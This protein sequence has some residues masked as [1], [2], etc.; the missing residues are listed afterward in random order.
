MLDHLNAVVSAPKR[1]VLIGAGGFVGGAIKSLLDT[2][3]VPTLG[4]TRR[5]IDLLG[6]GAT[7]KVAALL[8]PGDSVV[9]VSAIA[10]VKTVS[11][12]MQN[13]CMGQAVCDAIARAPIH[14]LLYISSDAVYADDA[15]P[16]TERS[17]CA[18]STLHGMMH[19]ARELMFKSSTTAPVAMLRPT[20]I[21]GAADPHGGYGPNRFRR[22]AA[23]GED[24][25]L[26]GE[27]EEQRDHVCIDDVAELARLIL[28]HRS[29]GALNA[30]TGIATSFNR[31]AHVIAHQFGDRVRVRETP[32]TV[33]RPHL[34][35][36][37]FDITACH[38]A[39]PQFRFVA[40]EEGLARAMRISQGE[41]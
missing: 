18:P 29:R 14:H 22:Q 5:E 11:M 24:I 4:I 9:I 13:L 21:Y 15:N 1:V 16:V 37:F 19:A 2:I 3:G 39:F 12:L 8:Q 30:A 20:L 31:I 38:R 27:G 41:S 36:R 7:A 28:F 6:D 32:R 17:Y 40:L 35:H 33:P 23:A 34:L 26:F 10:P 25:P